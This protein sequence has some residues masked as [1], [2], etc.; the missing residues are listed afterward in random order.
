MYL[1]WFTVI[2]SEAVRKNQLPPKL[3]I[4]FQTSPIAPPG[5]STVQNRFHFDSPISLLASSS[6]GGWLIREW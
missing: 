4:P 2:S 6:S 5:T 3:I 1:R